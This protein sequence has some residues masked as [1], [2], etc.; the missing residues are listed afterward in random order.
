M[1]KNF[2]WVSLFVLALGGC[3]SAPESSEDALGQTPGQTQEAL[4]AYSD[5]DPVAT[6]VTVR[7]T[8]G[9]REETWVFACDVNYQLMLTKI[10]PGVGS[11]G[12]IPLSDCMPGTTPAAMKWVGQSSD[13]VI[14]YWHDSFDDLWE[15]D[16]PDSTQYDSNFFYFSGGIDGV[17]R[18]K[19]SPVIA[20]LRGFTQ[21]NSVA[22]TRWEDSC[23]LTL[24]WSG[25]VYTAHEVMNG[26]SCM[27]SD[28]GNG[29]N[30]WPGGTRYLG[31]NSL[32]SKEVAGRAALNFTTSYS[33]KS[34]PY[35]VVTGS[36]GNVF[37]SSA[38]DPL[39][40]RGVVGGS[41]NSS[42]HPCNTSGPPVT[43]RMDELGGWVRGTSGALME[44]FVAQSTCYNRGGSV[45]SGLSSDDKDKY[46]FYKGTNGRLKY[47]DNST[48]AHVTLGVVLP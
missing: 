45:A 38:S 3:A 29:I 7:A 27:Q 46:V 37:G 35:N 24:D 32:G 9:G 47:Y 39:L 43:H 44:F 18:I 15:L 16:W 14:V 17:G 5:A 4:V 31:V 13:Y 21:E 48:A 33:R 22:Y 25:G 20:G 34:S 11:V 12:P 6:A 10:Q 19:G 42:W 30:A 36:T 26:S 28:T 2:Y 1:A 23:V 41:S 40:R 8:R